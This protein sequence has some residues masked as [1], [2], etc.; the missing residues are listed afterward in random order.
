[1]KIFWDFQ[2]GNIYVILHCGPVF[3][4]VWMPELVHYSWT[5]MECMDWMRYI[6]WRIR[7]YELNTSSIYFYCHYKITW[8]YLIWYYIF[9]A[10]IIC[11]LSVTD[12]W[13]S[14]FAN[15]CTT[16]KV[17]RYVGEKELRRGLRRTVYEHVMQQPSS[18]DASSE[19]FL[20]GFSVLIC[21]LIWW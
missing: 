8:T 1:M 3:L 9:P 19:P 4:L 12:G 10:V 20:C 21:L 13:V 5:C 6:Y 2:I 18:S 17:L 7:S 11:P 16:L 15:F 14:E